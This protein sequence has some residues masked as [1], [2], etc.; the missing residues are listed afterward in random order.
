VAGQVHFTQVEPRAAGIESVDH[1]LETR[2]V[3][4]NEDDFFFGW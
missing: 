4:E 2:I 3:V 1:A